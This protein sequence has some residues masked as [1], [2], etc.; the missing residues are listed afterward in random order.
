MTVDLK[1]TEVNVRLQARINY[2][3]LLL[4]PHEN[5]PVK[6]IVAAGS[7]PPE[8][9]TLWD[10]MAVEGVEVPPARS[11]WGAAHAGRGTPGRNAARWHTVPEISRDYGTFVGGWGRLFAEAGISRYTGAGS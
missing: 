5:R 3:N 6:R 9:Q 11:L 7:V 4:L 1:K 8:L 10:K 2:G